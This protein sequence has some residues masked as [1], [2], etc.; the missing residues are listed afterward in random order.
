VTIDFT[1]SPVYAGSRSD[2]LIE[3]LR[4]GAISGLGNLA[5]GIGI[6]EGH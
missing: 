1:Q 5:R 6:C 4:L 2:S 3:S